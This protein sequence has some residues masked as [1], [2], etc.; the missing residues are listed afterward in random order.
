VK[1]KKHSAWLPALSSS[2]KGDSL[3]SSARREGLLPAVALDMV[4]TVG[5]SRG[6]LPGASKHG[7]QTARL[8]G[9]AVA[10]LIRTLSAGAT[11][12]AVTAT[13]SGGKEIDSVVTAGRVTL[14]LRGALGRRPKIDETNS[15]KLRSSC[16]SVPSVSACSILSSAS[17]H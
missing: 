5:S 8:G 3:A 13:G 11:A 1:R 14:G 10:P 17:H 15:N 12:T 16:P 7:F 9:K 2:R 6:S 4:K